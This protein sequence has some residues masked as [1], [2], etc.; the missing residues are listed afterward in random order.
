[1]QVYGSAVDV[2]RHPGTETSRAPEVLIHLRCLTIGPSPLPPPQTTIPDFKRNNNIDGDLQIA[3]DMGVVLLVP[4]LSKV[5][6]ELKCLMRLKFE[7]A[8]SK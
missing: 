8:S 5:W 7:E 1:M 3:E 4:G 2:A 6:R